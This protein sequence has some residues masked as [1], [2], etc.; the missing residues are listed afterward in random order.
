MEDLVVGLCAKRGF[1]WELRLECGREVALFDIRAETLWDG[2]GGLGGDCQNTLVPNT[3]LPLKKSV[4]SK[5]VR[6]TFPTGAFAG[7]IFFGVGLDHE[8]YRTNCRTKH[9][10]LRESEP[11]GLVANQSNWKRIMSNSESL[12]LI[13]RFTETLSTEL[14]SSL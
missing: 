2:L 7:Q 11:F 10:S 3:P 9:Y 14:C 1:G 6:R 13:E 12:T 8:V 5:N 4:Y